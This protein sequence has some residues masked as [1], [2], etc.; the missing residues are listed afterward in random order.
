MKR[1]VTAAQ[2]AMK[3]GT[4][5]RKQTQH[6]H[7]WVMD[8]MNGLGW[9]GRT[10]KS[11]SGEIEKERENREE[12]RDPGLFHCSMCPNTNFPSG[13]YLFLDYTLP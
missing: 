4:K 13:R 8:G 11:Y 3:Q 2:V 12:K 9:A 1:M 5:K 6:E 10:D 7:I